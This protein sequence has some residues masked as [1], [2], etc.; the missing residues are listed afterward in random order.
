MIRN[1]SSILDDLMT[2]RLIVVSTQTNVLEKFSKD[3][4]TVVFNIHVLIENP[5]GSYMSSKTRK[6]SIPY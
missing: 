4:K 1:Q 2:F 5:F 3:S 6:E